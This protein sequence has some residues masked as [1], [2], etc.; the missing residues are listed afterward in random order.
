MSTPI[1]G[2]FLLNLA[3]LLRV[4]QPQRTEP[5]RVISSSPR[6]AKKG[7][8]VPGPQDPLDSLMG[9]LWPPRSEPRPTRTH[10]HASPV[11]VS[12]RTST[13]LKDGPCRQGHNWSAPWPGCL[14]SG[15][16]AHQP[17][18]RQRSWFRH[19]AHGAARN[20][21]PGGCRSAGYAANRGLSAWLG[22]GLSLETWG[23]FRL[24]AEGLRLQ[25]LG[26]EPG[27][28]LLLPLH[29]APS[30]GPWSGS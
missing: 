10:P 16:H 25:T 5:L 6:G 24:Q 8:Y 28:T 30:W 21:Q 2:S 19:E 13:P 4:P 9:L 15:W 7:P 1:K 18:W 23:S 26:L 22:L 12:R 20:T 3:S 27:G 29:P 11:K 14:G 17:S